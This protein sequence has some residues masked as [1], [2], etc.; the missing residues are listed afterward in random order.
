MGTKEVIEMQPEMEEMKPLEPTVIYTETVEVTKDT[1]TI[2]RTPDVIVPD[3][4]TIDIN[5][6]RADYERYKGAYES[7]SGWVR[8]WKEMMAVEQEKIDLY[9]ANK[10]EE[11]IEETIKEE[12][13]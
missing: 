7:A 13:K 9:E 2:T 3:V 11:I 6:V 4:K 1:I 5:T 12:I 10:P 8:H